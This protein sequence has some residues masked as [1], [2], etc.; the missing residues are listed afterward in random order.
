LH[1]LGAAVEVVGTEIVIEGGVL[2]H[3]VGG[4]EDRGG[5]GADRLFGAASGSVLMFVGRPRVWTAALRPIYALYAHKMPRFDPNLTALRTSF[6][7]KR[8]AGREP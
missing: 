6:R 2:E 7:C 1:G 8:A 3:V 4:G 5:E